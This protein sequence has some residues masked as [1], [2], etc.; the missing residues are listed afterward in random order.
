MKKIISLIIILFL[1]GC[2]APDKA[3]PLE[4]PV[5]LSAAFE[6]AFQR[7]LDAA[8][9][10]E[11]ETA[12]TYFKAA[13]QETPSYP[14]LIFNLGLAHKNLGRRLAALSWFKAYLKAVPDS[15]RA[16][17]LEPEIAALKS[18]LEY[19]AREI[20]RQAVLAMAELPVEPSN[21]R[22]YALG[23]IRHYLA[24]AGEIDYAVEVTKRYCSLVCPDNPRA[25][26]LAQYTE[27]LAEEGDYIKALEISPGQRHSDNSADK[28]NAAKAIALAQE[29]DAARIYNINS[30]IYDL[31]SCFVLIR[32]QEAKDIPVYLANLAEEYLSYLRRIEAVNSPSDLTRKVSKKFD[33]NEMGVTELGSQLI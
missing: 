2:N 29:V 1:S 4:K 15:P 21:H 26:A 13:A 30:P 8:K 33:A 9:N 19:A 28:V 11:W 31:K 23:F 16:Q 22:E 3:A 12:L 25:E 32:H 20:F 17:A 14:P 10:K 6:E 27:Q 18:D 24:C 7:G 5:V